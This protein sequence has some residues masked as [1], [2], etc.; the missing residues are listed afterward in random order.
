MAANRECLEVP[1]KNVA[2]GYFFSIFER[3]S[4]LTDNSYHGSI[5]LKG[6]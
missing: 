2:S 5:L 4:I 6:K 1:G 3:F